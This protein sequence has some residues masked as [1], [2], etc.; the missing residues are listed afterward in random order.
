MT[1]D[2]GLHYDVST[3]QAL[4]RLHFTGRSGDAHLARHVV[5]FADVIVTVVTWLVVLTILKNN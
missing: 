1:G 4:L 5:M 3:C 2:P